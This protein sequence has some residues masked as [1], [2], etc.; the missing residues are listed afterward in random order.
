MVAALEERVR[1]L[2]NRTV[3]SGTGPLLPASQQSG[4]TYTLVLNDRGTVVEFTSGSAITATVPPNSSVAFD[5][6][7][8]LEIHQYGAGQVTIAAGSGVT[9]RSDGGKVKTAAQYASI[10]LRQRAADEWVL[11]GDLA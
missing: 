6:G 9:L 3:A 2:E 11:T 8:I 10:G 5:I 7:T 1:A 4:M